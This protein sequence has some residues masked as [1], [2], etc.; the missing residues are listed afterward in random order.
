MIKLADKLQYIQE[1][2]TIAMA[3]AARAL[4]AKGIDV[5][6]LSL[7]EPDFDT[8]EHIKQAAIAAIHDNFTHYTP[9]AGIAEL[10]EAVCHKLK[11]DNNLHY[12]TENIVVSTGA[13]QSL[14]NAVMALVNKGDEVIIPTPFWVSY[15]E[16]VKLNEANPVYIHTSVQQHYKI[17]AEQLEAAITH[18]TKLFMFSSPCNPTGAFY[19]KN[20]LAQLVQVLLKYSDIY[21]I[22]DEIYEYINYTGSHCSIA[23]FDEIKNRV[24]VINGLSKG[25]AM[26]G[27]RL[28]Y[29]AAAKEIATACEKIQ[30][31]FTSATC[32][33][34]QKAAVAALTGNLE[35]TRQMTEMFRKRKN[36][37]QTA[38][39]KIPNIYCNNPEGAFYFFPD[40]SYYLNR[41]FDNLYI[42]TASDLCMYLLNH[43]HVS[44]VTGEAFGNPDCIRISYAASEK[45]LAEACNRIANALAKLV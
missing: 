36:L 21:I 41:K 19:N 10:K 2:Q 39:S 43:A 37:V 9:V 20:E 28:G 42:Q 26:T 14:M 12:E 25:F 4:A 40:I 13:K 32:S 44:L 16:M 15:S 11:R 5:I 18:K 30:S 3:K 8:P 34:T 31:Q 24:I 6:N 23:E 1:P 29:M 27:W 38:L 45:Q 35:P 17:T 22:S 33:I 7:G